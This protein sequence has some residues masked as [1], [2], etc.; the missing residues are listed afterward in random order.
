[1]ESLIQLLRDDRFM[2]HG[3]CYLWLPELLWANVVSDALIAFAY[4]TI[5]VTL[6]YF[7]RKRRDL[8]F[9]WM[10]GAFGVFILACGSTHVL[11]IWTIWHPDYWLAV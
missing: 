10:F 3:H 9:D 4:L 1:M 7:I 2:P 5:P 8:P 6:V 11:D